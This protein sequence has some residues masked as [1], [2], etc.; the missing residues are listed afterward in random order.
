[1]SHNL[2]G[3]LA[4]ISTVKVRPE[5]EYPEKKGKQ[6]KEQDLPDKLWVICRFQRSQ[7][8]SA[9]PIL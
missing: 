6:K 2:G 5:I 1:V 3:E 4:I 9:P 8:G 7:E